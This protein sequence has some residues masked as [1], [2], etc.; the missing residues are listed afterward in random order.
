M[1]EAGPTDVG[2]AAIVAPAFD[3]CSVFGD[4]VHRGRVVQ[5]ARNAVYAGDV[6]LHLFV[7]TAVLTFVVFIGC[8]WLAV[9][10]GTCFAPFYFDIAF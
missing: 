9:S 2:H 5:A 7:L 6:E 3:R 1:Y 4:R 8:D 10:N